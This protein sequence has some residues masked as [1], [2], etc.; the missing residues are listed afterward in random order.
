[1]RTCLSRPIASIALLWDSPKT[2]SQGHQVCKTSLPSLGSPPPG[3]TQSRRPD[4][5]SNAQLRLC[6][7][8]PLIVPYVKSGYRWHSVPVL[9][10]VA[11]LKI[12]SIFDAPRMSFSPKSWAVWSC[13]NTRYQPRQMSWL[14]TLYR[15]ALHNRSSAQLPISSGCIDGRPGQPICHSQP[16]RPMANAGATSQGHQSGAQIHSRLWHKVKAI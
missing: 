15:S 16:M 7:F 5:M 1:M 2:L 4:R 9:M 11:V 3:P 13:G 12:L 8:C 6:Q 10:R 14:V